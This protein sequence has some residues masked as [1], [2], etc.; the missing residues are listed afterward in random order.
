MADIL[1]RR[2]RHPALAFIGG[3]LTPGLGFLLTGRP[4]L[5]LLTWG[6]LAAAILA[7]PVSIIDGVLPIGAEYLLSAH[8][9]FFSIGCF[10]SAIVAGVLAARDPPRPFSAL[11]GPWLVLG[12]VVVSF[13]TRHAL[14]SR[15]LDAHV[16]TY[17]LVPE[18][19]MA[20][21]YEAWS[22]V[23]I[24]KRGFQPYKLA[25]NDVV[26]VRAGSWPK[27]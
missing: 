4:L 2:R 6:I 8:Y 12:F 17:G 18:T 20:P 15:V 7:L 19:S 5:A 22:R 13:A 1:A 3:Q 25:V 9:L 14:W 24:I 11:E 26:A 10:V 21:T 27:P 23:S 16:V